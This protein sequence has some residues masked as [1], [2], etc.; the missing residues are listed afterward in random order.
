[1]T[2]PPMER[3]KICR[4]DWM[5]VMAHWRGASADRGGGFSGVNRTLGISNK[6]G[7]CRTQSR[8]TPSFLLWG[9]LR[10]MVCGRSKVAREGCREARDMDGKN[11]DWPPAGPEI[12]QS[13]SQSVG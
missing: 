10:L 5:M 11:D 9:T 2:I 12:S 3:G 6:K 7:P 1:M 13:V 4:S 8:W